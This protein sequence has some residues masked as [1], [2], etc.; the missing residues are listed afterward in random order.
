MKNYYYNLS[1][2]DL[3]KIAKN[4]GIKYTNS[5]KKYALITKIYETEK[6]RILIRLKILL[7][8]S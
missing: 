4:L 8:L 6:N 3:R 1:V 2:P 7:Y 5:Y